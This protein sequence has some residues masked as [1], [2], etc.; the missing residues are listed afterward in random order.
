MTN[1]RRIFLRN[2]AIFTSLAVMG[3]PSIVQASDTKYPDAIEAIMTRRSVRAFTDKAVTDEQI[4]TILRA[5]MAAPSAYNEQ[6]WQFIV[7]KD[8]NKIEAAAKLNKYASWAKN[9]PVGILTCVDSSKI[10]HQQGY[11]I[12]DVSIATQNI[13]LAVHALGL[14]ATWTGIYPNEEVMPRFVQ[15]FNLPEN[16]TPLAYVPIGYPKKP[17]GRKDTFDTKRIRY[18]TWA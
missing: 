5:A 9:A 13:L 18:N 6:P 11:G 1:S 4:E 7:V 10:K 8:K 2:S 3:T 12:I 14:G 17:S 15:E 16:I